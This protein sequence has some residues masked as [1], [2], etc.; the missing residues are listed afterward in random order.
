MHGCNRKRARNT[1]AICTGRVEAKVP[2]GYNV[3]LTN[4]LQSARGVW[5]QSYMGCVNAIGV[6]LQSARGVWRQSS[7]SDRFARRAKLQSAR[8]VWRQSG[9]V[10]GYAQGINVAICTGRVEAKDRGC[11]KVCIVV[12]CNLHG[13]CGGKG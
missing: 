13:A 11:K 3:K 4:Q 9:I 1:V 2:N 7:I 12:R 5:R 6:T 8:G 10:L